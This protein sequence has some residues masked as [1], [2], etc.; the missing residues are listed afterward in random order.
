MSIL[1]NERHPIFCYR[2][3]ILGHQER[4]CPSTRRGCISVDKEDLQ[5]GP[6]LG[7]VDPKAVKG[8]TSSSQPN[9]D[10]ACDEE[11][12]ETEGND[13]H[14]ERE[15]PST[16][17]G[18]ISVD[19]E[20]LQYGPWLG[21]V[22]PKAVKG[23]TSSSQPNTN[24][25]SDEENLETEGNDGDK[26]QS[27]SYPQV[28][29][30]PLIGTLNLQAANAELDAPP[31]TSKNQSD[32]SQQGSPVFKKLAIKGDSQ[33]GHQERECPSTRRGCISV[34]EEDLQYGPWLGV[35]DP[36]AVKGKTSSSQP[37]TNEA[38]DEENLETEGNDGDKDQS[39][40]Y[41]QVLQL[42]LI[43]TL[44]LQAANAELDAPPK[45]SKNQVFS[46]LEN[47]I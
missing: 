27:P 18:C 17:R 22:D 14:Q 1:S 33:A 44:N 36:K 2:S 39:P 28:L 21:V 41:P 4:E 19:E 43:G 38:S 12:L 40:S 46:E 37:N 29:Q 10:E 31:K 5:Y 35:V 3:G 13:G 45:T 42:P 24:E 11:N 20:D 30:L 34:D 26:D 8:K 9:T 25:A 16:R 15:C 47:Q 23:K 6:W 32:C 7:V